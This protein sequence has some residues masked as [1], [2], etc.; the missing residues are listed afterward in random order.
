MTQSNYYVGHLAEQYGASFLTH[1]GYEIVSLNWTTPR[2]EVDIICRKANII[3]FVEVKYRK[4]DAQ[5]TGL[6]YITSR[7]LQQMEYAAESWVHL[8]GWTGDYSLAALEI[9]GPNYAIA[10]FIADLAG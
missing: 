8:N 9:A 5:G 1:E 4:N 10:E 3:Y 2:C 6:D 7:K